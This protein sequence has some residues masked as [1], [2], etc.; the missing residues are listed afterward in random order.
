MFSLGQKIVLVD[1]Q[2]TETVLDLYLSLP[3]KD[4]VYVVRQTRVG[5]KADE[6]IMDQRRV[7]EQSLLLVG[8]ENPSN[9]LGVEYGFAASRFR[10]L[11]FLQDKATAE[12]EDLIFK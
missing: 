2:W 12:K 7:L 9:N 10:S 1:D 4:S 11:E 5:V 3:I 6:L 8:I